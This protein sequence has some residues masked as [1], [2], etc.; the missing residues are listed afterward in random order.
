MKKII[1][2]GC[3]LTTLALGMIA[4][5]AYGSDQTYGD[6]LSGAM[7]IRISDLTGNPEQYVD[8]LVK[9]EGLV[10]DVCPMKGCWVDILEAQSGETMRF[11]VQDDVIVFPVE[12]RGRQI[13]AEGILRKHNLTRQQAE[14]WMRHL[15]EEKGEDFDADSID[16]A[17]VFYQIEGV[18]AVVYEAVR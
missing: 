16:G 18:G 11:K 15:A 14:K 9:I 3:W 2:I 6:E 5:S 4:F 7:S 8:Q 1:R 17:M 12:A 13:V 10:D